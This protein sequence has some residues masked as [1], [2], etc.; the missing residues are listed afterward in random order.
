MGTMGVRSTLKKL[1]EK[2][3]DS[4]FTIQEDNSNQYKNHLRMIV[5]D[6]V[7]FVT[8]VKDGKVDTSLLPELNNLG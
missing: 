6:G 4:T 1:R 7:T 5:K 2:Y 3:P 8:W